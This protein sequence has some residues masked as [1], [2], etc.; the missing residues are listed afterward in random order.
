[1]TRRY[2]VTAEEPD[3]AT[4]TVL[5]DGP[6]GDAGQTREFWMPDGGGYVRETSE[7][8]PGTLGLQVCGGL[9]GSGSTLYLSE[10]GNLTRLIRREAAL[11]WR[12][13]DRRERY[14]DGLTAAYNRR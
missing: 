9:S 7:R 13:W 10:G 8:R 12:H 1:M 11:A 6:L 5:A 14:W 4:L 2:T 3:R